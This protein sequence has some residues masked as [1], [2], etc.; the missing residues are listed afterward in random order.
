MKRKETFSMTD[1]QLLALL[2]ALGIG[3][4]LAVWWQ[5]LRFGQ[6]LL[7]LSQQ[8][9]KIFVVSETTLEVATELLRRSQQQRP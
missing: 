7:R 6:I 1:T 3:V 9:E 4:N 5:S 8:Q 2:V